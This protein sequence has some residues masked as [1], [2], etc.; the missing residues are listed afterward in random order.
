MSR[1][2]PAF[3]ASGLAGD[4]CDVEVWR[5]VQKDM[6]AESRASRSGEG[7]AP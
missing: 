3:I 7:D 6:L 4:D 5:R 2:N 1:A